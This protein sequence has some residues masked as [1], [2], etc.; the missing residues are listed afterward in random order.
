[1]FSNVAKPGRYVE[2]F[3]GESWSENV[4]QDSRPKDEDTP[5]LERARGLNRELLAEA[6]DQRAGG[7]V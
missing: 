7:W 3:I 2:Y 1:M 5:A 6:V 4:R